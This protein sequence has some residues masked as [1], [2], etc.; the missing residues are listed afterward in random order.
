MTFNKQTTKIILK[1][2]M[3]F[4]R[5]KTVWT[6]PEIRLTLA[7]DMRMMTYTETGAFVECLTRYNLAERSGD[8][9]RIIRKK[10]STTVMHP[11]GL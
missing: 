6:I 2:L 11:F 1:E 4:R 7:L 9:L 5:G 8:M 10:K 3:A